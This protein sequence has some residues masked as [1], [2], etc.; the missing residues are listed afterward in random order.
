MYCLFLDDS[1]LSISR[2]NQF[3]LPPIHVPDTS[4]SSRLRRV[5]FNDE[6]RKNSLPKLSTK[7]K[8][9]L[10]PL[11]IERPNPLPPLNLN[12][13]SSS[14]SRRN[15]FVAGGQTRSILRKQTSLSSSNASTETI[16]QEK[17]TPSS[18]VTDD[19]PLGT[20]SQLLF[21]GSECFAQIMNEL[22]QHEK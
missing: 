19:I 3:V 20:R 12:S 13:S 4:T 22:E 1:F 16:H 14:S 2:N 11:S 8:T 18:T 21:G 15:G 6:Q 7:N 17:L 5:D 9:R 10:K